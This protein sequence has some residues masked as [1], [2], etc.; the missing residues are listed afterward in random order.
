MDINSLSREVIGAAIEV[1]RN[2]GPGLLES[3]YQ[4]C[5]FLELKDRNISFETQARVPIHYKDN[6]IGKEFILDF[7]IEDYMVVE[8]KSLE[9]VLPVHKAQLLTYLKL[10]NKWLGLLI[11]FNEQK[12]TDGISRIVHNFKN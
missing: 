4:H 1:H 10:S 12:L 11:N 8:L 9:I 3:V 6:L 5:L 2:L 7:L